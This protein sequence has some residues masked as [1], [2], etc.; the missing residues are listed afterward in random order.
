MQG[1]G[2]YTPKFINLTSWVQSTEMACNL[3]HCF[4][5]VSTLKEA[6]LN[7]WSEIHQEHFL[8]VKSFILCQSKQSLF[9]LVEIASAGQQFKSISSEGVTE[10]STFIVILFLNKLNVL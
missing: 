6:D 10:S 4:Q 1:I 5:G 7:D 2:T 9:K 8:S 3:S